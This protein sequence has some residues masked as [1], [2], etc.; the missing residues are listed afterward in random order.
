MHVHVSYLRVLTYVCVLHRLS[1][2]PCADLSFGL[3]L[4]SVFLLEYN[5]DLSVMSVWFIT[6]PGKS[7]A[8]HMLALVLYPYIPSHGTFDPP[9]ARRARL[10]EL[11]RSLRN[12]LLR[13]SLAMIC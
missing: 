11:C 6:R 7:V 10:V 13:S 3:D 1:Y 2:G 8:Y 4:D 12:D 9:S 5:V